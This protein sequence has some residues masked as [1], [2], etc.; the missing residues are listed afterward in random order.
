M[1]YRSI[2]YS[3]K[4]LI[5]FFAGIMMFISG[6]TKETDVETGFGESPSN[7]NRTYLEPGIAITFDDGYYDDW[8]KMLPVL[9]KYNAKVTFFVSPNYP[10]KDINAGE[11]IMK[12]YN[13][14]NEIGLHTINHPHLYTYLKHHSLK[15][16]Y[17]NEILPGVL[18]LNSLGINPGSFAYPFGEYNAESNLLLSR[19][20]NKI[21]C[22]WGYANIKKVKKV[23]GAS[24]WTGTSL[25]YYKYDINYAKLD[26][27][28]WVLVAHRPV[29]KATGNDPFTFAMLDSICKFV[30]E[31]NMRFYCLQEIDSIILEKQ[32]INKQK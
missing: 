30:K 6:C 4:Y 14:G 13:A 25:K 26:S 17:K 5:S 12:L 11:K 3:T 32:R 16:Y 7:L 24:V 27:S 10:K 1:N 28:I 23:T 18:F 22:M 19:Y 2:N 8:L 21:R 20:F 15:D 31:Q 9:K 29:K